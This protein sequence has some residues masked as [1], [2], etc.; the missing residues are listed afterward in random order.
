MD[1]NKGSRTDVVANRV[2]GKPSSRRK[3]LAVLRVSIAQYAGK[4]QWFVPDAAQFFCKH[5]CQTLIEPF[6]GSAIV[7]L[8]LIH[9]GMIERLVLVEKDRRIALL[10]NGL[11]HDPEL[12]D[13][14]EAFNCTLENVQNLLRTDQSAFR[15]LVESR[16]RNRGRFDG[17]LSK[18][19]DS[20]WCRD[21]VVANI[22]RV[23][24][25]R[26]RIEVVNGDALEEMRKYAADRTVGCFADPPYTADK[27]SKGHLMYRHHRLEHKK[28]FKLLA[29]WRGP[30]LLTED[31][32]RMVRHLA[33]CYRFNIRRVRM[34]TSDNRRKTELVMW[35]KR[36]V[37]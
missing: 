17:G 27:S 11:V 2:A 30:W 19:I 28:L 15:Y 26:D 8:S 31:N 36:R 18:Q 13:R 14:Y 35:R 4:K 6:A 10:L 9:A 7:G 32:S 22:R 24:A 29:Q 16:C 3:S 1:T 33:A 37:F 23:Y 34:M 12:A 25:M 5:P 20:H 21:L